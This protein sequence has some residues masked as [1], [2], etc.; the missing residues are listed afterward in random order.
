[1]ST[2]ELLWRKVVPL[3][4]R[5][6]RPP[7]FTV[8]AVVDSAI[9]VADRIGSRFTLRDVA[10]ELGAP[11]MSLYSYVDNREQ[12]VE[13]MV[14]Q[15][16]ADMTHSE[17]T[18]TWQS[19]LRQVAADNLNLFDRH[20]WLVDVESE[21]AILG[22]GTLGK[23]ERELGAVESLELSDAAKDAALQL[24][25]NFVRASARSLHHAIAERREETPEQWWEREG[26]QLAKLSVEER[27]PLAS[28]IG[29]AA[30]QATG[31]AENADAA[32]DFGLSALLLGIEAMESAGV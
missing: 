26:A 30:G 15:C 29:T 1:M 27:Y 32:R 11:V 22:P 7:R 25:L 13:L 18:G 9:V 24:V 28:R 12:L 21:R 2:I 16:R 14:D 8:D 23:Y 3:P 10:Q 19:R 20:P 6:G 5:Q 31:A 4:A 17:L